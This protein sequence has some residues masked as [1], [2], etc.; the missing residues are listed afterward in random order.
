MSAV[1][2]DQRGDNYYSAVMGATEKG[3]RIKDWKLRPE[4]YGRDYQ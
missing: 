2:T 3:G 1:V 4:F